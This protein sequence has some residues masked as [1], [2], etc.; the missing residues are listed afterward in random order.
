MSFLDLFRDNFNPV[1]IRI[2]SIS[3]F[4]FLLKISFFP[5]SI[6]FNLN[7]IF[8]CLRKAYISKNCGIRLSEIILYKAF[9]ALEYKILGFRFPVDLGIIGFQGFT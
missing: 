5:I 2:F 1:S 6:Y 7:F 8:T 4:F 3:K 9:N